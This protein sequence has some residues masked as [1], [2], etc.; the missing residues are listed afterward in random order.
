MSRDFNK[1]KIYKITNDYN[2]DVYVGSTCD[3]LGKR[4]SKHKSDAK[5]E[6]YKHRKL[7]MLMNEIGFERFR[8]QLIIDYPCEDI[9]QLTQKEGE[10]IRLLGTLNKNIAG[11]TYKEWY[12]QYLQKPEVKE[13]MKQ[14]RQKPEVKEYQKTYHQNPEM[15]SYKKE[16]DKKPERKE[17]MK[18]YSQTTQ[19]KS[20][21]KQYHTVYQVEN[22][23]NIKTRTKQR[24][25][26][27]K[28]KI[29]EKIRCNC[30]CEITK[31]GLQNH[32]NTTKHV[33]LMEQLK[34]ITNNKVIV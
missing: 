1:A 18:Q 29:L 7:F 34:S 14:Y 24:Y 19:R 12:N 22:R 30:G 25:E 6:K 4:F 8:I 15:K 26:N 33:N 11:R 16:Y 27:N 31:N 32:L 10:Y 5:N 2:D 13:Q 23:E 17:Y 9:Y 20:Y 28:Q 21:Q 3:T